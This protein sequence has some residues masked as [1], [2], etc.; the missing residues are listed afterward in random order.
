MS[1]YTIHAPWEK[2][3]RNCQKYIDE[4]LNER[5]ATYATLIEGMDK[6]LGDIMEE[7]DRLGV[8]DTTISIFTSDNVAHGEVPQNLPLR[9]Y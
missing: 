9:G 5:E 7:L 2:D 8:A 3:E 6:S 1:H 4:G